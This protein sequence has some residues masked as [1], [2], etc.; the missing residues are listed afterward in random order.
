MNNCRSL[1]VGT[2]TGYHLLSL[3]SVEHIERIYENGMSHNFNLSLF[4]YYY[5]FTFSLILHSSIF[6]LALNKFCSEVN[7]TFTYIF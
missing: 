1:A 6:I 4:Y 3:S 5:T 2:K 7:N